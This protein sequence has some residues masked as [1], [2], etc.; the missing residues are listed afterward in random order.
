[1]SEFTSVS[2]ARAESHMPSKETVPE[3]AGTP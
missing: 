1:M 2:S 3:L